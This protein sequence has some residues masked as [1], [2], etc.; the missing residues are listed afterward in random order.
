MSPE[1]A[2]QIKKSQEYFAV[3][4]QISKS[5][6]AK[7]L[8]INDLSVGFTDGTATLSGIAS[9]KETKEMA[10]KIAKENSKVKKVS[11]SIQV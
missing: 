10:T 2:E 1:I 6:K 5:I 3:A 8:K 4:Q 9:D 11:N 7:K